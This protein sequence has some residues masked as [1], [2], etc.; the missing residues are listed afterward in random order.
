MERKRIP[1]RLRCDECGHHQQITL[2]VPDEMPVD[3][4]PA[5]VVLP[6]DTDVSKLPAGEKH[7][8]DFADLDETFFL[9]AAVVPAINGPYKA[10]GHV[11]GKVV[12]VVFKPLGTEAVS[13]ISMRPASRRERNAL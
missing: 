11:D 9:S 5:P 8:L 6:R 10:L 12:S 1:I 4:E 13:I 7:G 3:V 2:N